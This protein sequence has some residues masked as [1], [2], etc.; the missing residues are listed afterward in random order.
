MIFMMNQI[1]EPALMYDPM[2]IPAILFGCGNPL[3]EKEDDS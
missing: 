2:S 1:V 3:L